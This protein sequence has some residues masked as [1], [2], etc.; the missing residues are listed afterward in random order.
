VSELALLESKVLGALGLKIN[1][2]GGN[3]YQLIPE[4]FKRFEVCPCCM[5]IKNTLPSNHISY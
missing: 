1:L 4:K 5:L 2:W 3:L